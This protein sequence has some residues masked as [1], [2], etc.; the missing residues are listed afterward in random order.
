MAVQLSFP[1]L[2]RVNVN[3]AATRVAIN[4][5]NSAVQEPVEAM[6]PAPQ[7]PNFFG[8]SGDLI[9]QAQEAVAK[10]FTEKA[11]EPTD[12]KEAA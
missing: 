5:M 9:G 7:M 3:T 8:Q 1:E 11:E 12:V 4:A 10:A 2:F 6:K